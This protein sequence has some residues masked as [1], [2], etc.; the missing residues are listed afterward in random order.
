VRGAKPIGES[1]PK[2]CSPSPHFICWSCAQL[3][4]AAIFS[5]HPYNCYHS[6]NNCFYYFY[7]IYYFYYFYYLYYT[8]CF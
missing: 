7:H 6:N 3:S 2:R 8:Y 4:S 1:W 5:I